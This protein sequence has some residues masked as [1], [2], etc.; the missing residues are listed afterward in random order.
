[1]LQI[2]FSGELSHFEDAHVEATLRGERLQRGAYEIK[3]LTA[4]AEWIEQRLNVSQLQWTDRAGE[5][6][7]QASWR[8][9]DRQGDFQLHSTV[10]TKG[11]LDAFGFANLLPDTSFATPPLIECSGTLNFAEATPRISALGR[12]ALG[13]FTYKGVSLLG[14]TAEYSWD[15][16]RT[17]LRDV[18]VRHA[19]GEVLADLLDAPGDFRLT[20]ESSINPSAFRALASEDLQKFLGEWEWPRSPAVHLEIRGASRD[21]KTWQGD[22]T[23]AV[24]RT[25]FRGVWMNSAAADIHFANEAID[26]NDLRVTRDEGTGTGSFTYDFG[27]HEVRIRNVKTSLRPVDVIHWI[28]PKLLKTVTPYKFHAPPHLVANGVVQYRGGEKTHLEIAIDAPAGLD[29]GFLGKTLS[30]NR[31]RGDL[32]IT[33]DRVQLLGLEG[34]LFAGTVRG[35]A[36]IS[37]AKNNSHYSATVA[38][39]GVDFPRLTD[40]YFKYETARGLLSG[41]YDFRGVGDE[42]RT[43]EGT[44]K[45]KVSNGD[46]FAIPVFGPLSGFV[47]AILP[48]VGYSV[49]K[50]ATASFTIKDGVIRTDDFKVSG[51]LFGIVGHGNIHF[52][53]NKLDFDV[54]INANGPGVVLTPVYKLF[55]YKGEG[56]LA[57][58]NWH[59]KRF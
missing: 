17:M 54:R 38:V 16:A 28:E 8:V 5:F 50:E 59:P 58:P 53:E 12:I 41:T 39:E 9:Q 29:Y 32:L 10:D 15:G 45:I 19:S 20:I 22:G 55:E 34:T 6:S 11:L 40:L 25:R 2:K 49:A 14:L 3:T 36:D 44:G 7:A 51:K 23:V 37:V 13:N 57:K 1:V 31:A 48:G 56:S 27:H 4:A 26:F 24:Q 46:V 43:M 18:R 33:D 52:L 30:F 21:A 42:A 35:T 47:A